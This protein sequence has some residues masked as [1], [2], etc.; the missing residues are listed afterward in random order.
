MQNDSKLGTT[1]NNTCVDGIFSRNINNV[2]CIRYV[3]YFSTHR[4]LILYGMVWLLKDMKHD[5]YFLLARRR[6]FIKRL[7][8]EK[9]IHHSVFLGLLK[10][11]SS[12]PHK[13]GIKLLKILRGAIFVPWNFFIKCVVSE[14][15][16]FYS[17]L[18]RITQNPLIRTS[19]ISFGEQFPYRPTS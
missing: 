9:N 8:L 10:F 12:E 13:F 16:L 19:R 4:P 1:R 17:V 14:K 5:L 7:L 15:N 2:R 3:S 6:F 18:L 11:Y